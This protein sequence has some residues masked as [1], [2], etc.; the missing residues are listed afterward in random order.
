MVVYSQVVVGLAS[1]KKGMIRYFCTYN[2]MLDFYVSPVN[3]AASQ[4]DTHD[5]F[6]QR[7]GVFGHFALIYACLYSVQ[8]LGSPQG[9]SHNNN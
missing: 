2:S 7:T 3:H 6:A 5:F 4:V 9:K 1:V 8:P